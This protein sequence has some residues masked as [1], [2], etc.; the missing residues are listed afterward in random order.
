ML[1][2]S[3]T[4]PGLRACRLAPPGLVSPLQRPRQCAG[5][6]SCR[7][8][9]QTTCAAS[10]LPRTPLGSTGYDVCALGFG[11][12]PL[13][14]IYGDISESKA[15]ATVHEAFKQGINY[16]DSSPF[17]G[18]GLSEIRLG[19]GL[20]EL[21][22]NEVVLATKFG[23]YG[24][25]LFDFSAERVR[26]GL[27]ESMERL[28]VDY[29]DIFQCHDIEFR[30]LDQIVEETIPE[31]VK[32]KEEGLIRHIGITGLPLPIYKKVLDRLPKG[33][34]DVILAYCHNSLNDDS[35]QG[36]VPYLKE[37]G[38]GI[39]SASPMSMGLMT[40]KGT[41]EWNPA[42]DHLKATCMEAAKHAEQQGVPLP[43]LALKHS[44]KSAVDADI[45]VTLV[46]MSSPEEVQS[47]VQAAK[48]AL[49]LVRSEKQQE[50]DRVLQEVEK[51]LQPIKNL[52]W[53]SGRPE[54]N[55]E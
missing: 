46:G 16:F 19:K 52:T 4:V 36:L 47:N 39:I 26:E 42:P 40:T 33:T 35:L 17:Y 37:Q 43:K 23:R 48:E 50:E 11:A 14:A 9:K 51:M 10:A 54:N 38:V 41:A 22:R 5:V 21:P 25:N 49:G 27:K 30:S 32:L 45:A 7:S 3:A 6:Q 1:Q 31:L 20:Q 12:S 28:Q 24:P 34:V 15:I 29:V 2:S 18:E 8:R 13:G 55:K 53:P 44:I